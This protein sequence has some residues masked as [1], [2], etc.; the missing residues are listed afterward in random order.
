LIDPV[1]RLA[2]DDK[3]QLGAGDGTL[4][5]PV[6]PR[7]LDVPGFWDGANI[8]RRAITPLFTVTVLDDDGREIDARVTARRWT[9]AELTLQYRLGSGITATEVRT[10]HPGG[11]FVSEWRFAAFRPERIHLVAWTAQRASRVEKGSAAWNGA[12]QFVVAAKTG[13]EDRSPLR[14][15]VELACVGGAASWSAM[16]SEGPVPAPEWA[17]TPF[18]EQ[19]RGGLLPKTVRADD[20]APDGG[21]FFAAVHRT[22]EVEY[23][24]AA[25]TFAMRVAP[26]DAAD[27]KPDSAPAGS[28]QGTFGGTSRR[29]WTEYFASLPALRCSDP[30]IEALYWHRWYVMRVNANAPGDGAK[31]AVGKVRELRWTGD[32]GAARDVLR[33][34]LKKPAAAD[35]GAALCALD[36]VHPDAAF[37]GK[38]LKKVAAAADWL[39]AERDREAGGLFDIARDDRSLELRM[40]PG[41]GGRIKG[42]ESSVYAYR[43]F[44]WLERAARADEET[45]KWK[46]LADLTRDAIRGKMWNE[47]T[48]LFSDVDAKM[49]V[50]TDVKHP[51]CFLPYETDI[52]DASHTAGLAKHLFNP[53]EFFTEFPVASLS[54]D[55]PRFNA[56]GE[57]KSRRAGDPWNGRTH[58][59]VTAE[60]VDAAAHVART[61]APEL[62]E[63]TA[64][65]LRR[66]VRMMFHGGE[67]SQVNSFDH[68]NPF[69][70]HA[71]VYR[72]VDDVQHAWLND[73]IIRHI[74][75]VSASA[76][77][78][79]I[80]PLPFGLELVE[81]TGLTVRGK[82][83]DVLITGASVTATIDGEQTTGPLGTPMVFATPS[84]A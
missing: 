54:A 77:G 82:S 1:E 33:E 6:F 73:L 79:T 31:N 58:P 80:D 76:L 74:V 29:R 37:T 61:R 36:D 70:G 78:I 52:A 66:F 2:R 28:R 22:L 67:L 15:R 60:V 53:A 42:I 39:V 50:H 16:R 10:V 7:W 56:E 44:R 51:R 57:W 59:E 62:R 5:A 68:Y 14:V 38:I 12:L 64:A 30:Y 81:I 25:A 34:F 8:L 19:W 18:V 48:G 43:L 17:L 55:D 83:V 69:T 13:E 11:I 23:A 72:G 21:S 65:L 27:Q 40:P 84:T 35:W 20:D 47:A 26:E 46:S 4:F 41:D 63:N 71:S 45:T 75:G 49:L 9:P 32:A 24:G 3:W